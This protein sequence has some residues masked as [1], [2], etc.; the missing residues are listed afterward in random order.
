MKS[1]CFLLCCSLCI[2]SEIA[3]VT[4]SDKDLSFYQ[5][6]L[7]CGAA[8][9]IGCGTRAKPILQDFMNNE[10]VEEAWLNHTGTVI[11]IVWKENVENRLELANSIFSDWNRPFLELTGEAREEHLIDFRVGKWY[12]GTDVDQLSMIEAGRIAD[13]LTS[14]IDDEANISEENKVNLRSAFESYIKKDFLAIEDA[15]VIDQASYWQ[16][17]ERELT[18]IGKDLLGNQMPDVKIIS[19]AAMEG[20]PGEACCTKKNS[21]ACCT[22]AH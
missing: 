10:Q 4:P 2:T 9:D 12:K 13:R 18:E 14:W 1:I 17:W 15:S 3:G 20:S 11:A 5:I 8:S 16:R 6:N 22:K 7:V 21:S 19:A